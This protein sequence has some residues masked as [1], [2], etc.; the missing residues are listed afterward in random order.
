[1]LTRLRDAGLAPLAESE[2]G[3]VHLTA[4]ARRRGEPSRPRLSRG[5]G[6]DLGDAHTDLADAEVEAVVASIRTGD[7]VEAER[8]DEPTDPAP[9]ETIGLLGLASEDKLRTWI[10][11]VDH[12]GNASE[13]IVAPVLVADC[14]LTAYCEDDDQPRT[15]ALH[16]IAAAR[17]IDDGPRD[18]G[19][20]ETTA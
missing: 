9:A 15:Y 8:P 4:P 13:R 5:T 12:N 14:W 18:T 7:R 11:Y 10:S 19:T 3:G 6:R 20:E 2:D 17:T 16:R 1:M